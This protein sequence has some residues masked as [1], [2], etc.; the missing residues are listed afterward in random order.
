[1][2]RKIKNYCRE[3]TL[4]TAKVFKNNSEI[5][6]GSRCLEFFDFFEQHYSHYAFKYF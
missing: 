4:C 1:M 3:L 5:S 6:Q 2:S